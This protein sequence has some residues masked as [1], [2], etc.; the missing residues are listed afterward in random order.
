MLLVAAIT[1]DT[2]GI[3]EKFVT[4]QTTDLVSL[5][6]LSFPLFLC[7]F[8]VPFPFSLDIPSFLAAG[9]RGD[10]AGFKTDLNVHVPGLRTMLLLYQER[11]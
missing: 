9:R 10:K 1:I 5:P 3:V 11:N 6:T 8:P 4:Y 7:L 2:W